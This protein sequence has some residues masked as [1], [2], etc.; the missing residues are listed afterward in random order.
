MAA[1]FILGCIVNVAFNRDH[2]LSKAVMVGIAAPGIIT[3]I[4]AGATSGTPFRQPNAIPPLAFFLDGKDLSGA[5][6]VTT[7][8]AAPQNE[9]IL[10]DVDH[11]QINIRFLTLFTGNN[12]TIRP[13]LRL[14][15][16]T[17]HGNVDAGQIPAGT[18]SPIALPP[19]SSGV[20]VTDGTNAGEAKIPG[21]TR[22]DATLAIAVIVR[23]GVSGWW[24]FGAERRPTVSDINVMMLGSILPQCP[25][26]AGT[27]S[28][29]TETNVYNIYQDGC[30]ITAEYQVRNIN[31]EIHGKPYPCASGS[32][33]CCRRGAQFV[34]E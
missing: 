9:A 25:N 18:W 32:T 19:G 7:A 29:S 5:G 4:V 28:S 16:E 24:V 22:A 21:N 26:I 30:V 8:A 3:N 13:L 33:K 20:R 27:W 10:G 23:T 6:F 1:F 2:D 31:N 15:A 11:T 14:Q 34:L 17:M 12:P